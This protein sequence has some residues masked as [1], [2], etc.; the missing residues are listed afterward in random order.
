MALR[1][2]G[3]MLSQASLLHPDLHDKPGRE[4]V[5]QPPDTSTLEEALLLQ[6]YTGHNDTHKTGNPYGQLQALAVGQ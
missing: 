4:G 2:K 3:K 1:W 6:L 5:S